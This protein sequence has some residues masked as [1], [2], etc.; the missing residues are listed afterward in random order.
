MSL[1]LHTVGLRQSAHGSVFGQEAI[2]QV[3]H[4]LADLLVLGQH[5]VVIKHHPQ[6]LLQREGAGEL[7]HSKKTESEELSFNIGT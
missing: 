2:L 1:N 6:V 3:N 4:R 7:K 5:V